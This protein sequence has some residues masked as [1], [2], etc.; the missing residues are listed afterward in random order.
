MINPRERVDSPRSTPEVPSI[1]AQKSALLHGSSASSPDGQDP[2]RQG[3]QNVERA[4][5]P[6]GRSQP[7]AV[8][9]TLLLSDRWLGIKYQVDGIAHP[10]NR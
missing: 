4:R 7:H 3:F 1:M 2:A 9:E 10:N 5:S 6:Q 8:K